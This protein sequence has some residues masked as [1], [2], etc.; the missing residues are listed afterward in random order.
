VS[1]H[2]S[3]PSASAAAARGDRS[4]TVRY[5][6]Y[7]KACGSIWPLRDAP[8]RHWQPRAQATMPGNVHRHRSRY[9]AAKH[10]VFVSAFVKSGT[11]WPMQIGHQLLF[12]GEGDFEH[13]HCVIPWLDGPRSSS[14]PVKDPSVWMASPEHKRVIKSHLPWEYLPYSRDARYIL[15]IR[16]PKDVFVS[17]YFFFRDSLFGP[18]MPSVRTWYRLFLSESLWFMTAPWAHHTAGYWA[19]RR[20]PNVLLL[21]F[22]AMRRDIKGTTRRIADFLGVHAA[23]DVLDR[24]LQK[25]SFGYMKQ[26]DHKFR[27][28]PW[29]PWRRPVMMRKGVQGGSSELLTQEQQRAMD[30]HF[31]AEF[32]RLGSDFPYEEFCDVAS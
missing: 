12:H 14:I 6:S 27:P 21:S 22:K 31:I 30:A 15:V 9:V 2:V 25:S 11:N 5:G 20:R 32:K 13:V 18:A 17:S 28:W 24:V 19:Q 29:I 3:T 1:L 26:I 16:D 4:D 8:S 7:G 10:D 23:E